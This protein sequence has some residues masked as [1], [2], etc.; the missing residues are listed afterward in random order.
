MSGTG[1]TGT[2]TPTPRS[3][4]IPLFTPTRG[5]K[6]ITNINVRFAEHPTR[7]EASIQL[8]SIY[9]GVLPDHKRIYVYPLTEEEVK[10]TDQL[11][12]TIVNGISDDMIYPYATRTTDKSVIKPIIKAAALHIHVQDFLPQ[13]RLSKN[14]MTDALQVAASR[15]R[16]HSIFITVGTSHI[17][18][19]SGPLTFLDWEFFAL[20]PWPASSTPVPDPVP[21]AADIGAAVASAITIP[22]PFAMDE[23]TAALSAGIAAAVKHIREYDDDDDTPG[24]GLPP[25]R[26]GDRTSLLGH[27]LATSSTIW[28]F[29]SRSLPDDVAR[30]FENKKN[31]GVVTSTMLTTR[32]TGGHFYFQ[33]RDKII[34][35]DG[36]L[37][38]CQEPNE[39]DL[40]KNPVVCSNDTHAGIRRWYDSFVKH[41]HGHGF[42]AHPLWCFRADHGGARG[43]TCGD[44][45]DD[46]LPLM[47]EVPTMKME[48]IILRLLQQKNMF[49]TGSRLIDIANSCDEGYVALKS[50]LFKSHPAFNDQPSTL[51]TTYPKQRELPF[52]TYFALFQDYLQLR[53]YIRGTDTTLND[54]GEL[55]IV[56]SNAKYA[57][58]I[59]RVSRD[60]RRIASKAHKYQGA[61]LLE[62]LQKILNQ[63]DSPALKDNKSKSNKTNQ[64]RGYNKT[65]YDSQRRDGTQRRVQQLGTHLHQLSLPQDDSIPPLT[66][67]GSDDTLDSVAK[68]F[69]SLPPPEDPADAIY[70]G[71]LPDHKRIYVG[72]I[73]EEEEVKSTEQLATTIVNAIAD[74]M[75]HPYATRTTDKSVIKPITKAAALHIHVQYFLPQ[76]RLKSGRGRG[77]PSSAGS[78]S[79]NGLKLLLLFLL[80]ASNL[81][82][83]ASMN[84]G[85]HNFLLPE[86]ANCT[87]ENVGMFMRDVVLPTI[88]KRNSC[89]EISD[90]VVSFEIFD[91]SSFGSIPTCPLCN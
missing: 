42:Y 1:T 15:N 58:Y 47:M 52:L 49:P 8:N 21:T 31:K 37:F 6:T 12:T 25:Y 45:A 72:P 7:P 32:F 20:R 89:G 70:G 41:L 40:L 4:N 61:Q 27:P 54:S 80:V 2:T 75:I 43:F 88:I 63:P 30:R 46:D 83:A 16:P 81:V 51:L 19:E 78:L 73:T 60:E 24:D 28:T 13:R 44:D 87:I 29:D 9:G 90:K 56:I 34:L 53:A 64:Y 39:K 67:S 76:R 84:G 86:P 55:D 66:T 10:P 14:S 77:V 26:R 62:T 5:F 18:F 69:Y 74:D 50:I 35:S 11:A 22:P 71:V 23:F 17:F 36:T 57:D 48:Q 38:L 79:Q 33:V 91:S 68:D 65:L 82:V 85:V 59:N 3:S